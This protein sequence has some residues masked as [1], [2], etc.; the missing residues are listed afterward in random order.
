VKRL[1]VSCDCYI[2]T[3]G[4]TVKLPLSISHILS[5][6]VLFGFVICP[7][8]SWSAQTPHANF[9]YPSKLPYQ[10]SNF[11][12]WNE[13]DL[14][15]LL[16]KRIPGLGEELAT[17]H[18]AERGV[19][20][21]LTALLKE[22]GIDAEVQSDEPGP[23]A[24][25]KID[26]ALFGGHPPEE[27]HPAITFSLLTPRVL[28]GKLVFKD[29]PE[30]VE[31]VLESEVRGTEGRPF[32]ASGNT[33]WQKSLNQVVEREGYLESAVHLTHQTPR[34]DG[35]RYLVDVILSVETGPRYHISSITADGGP[36]LQGKDL[37]R[38]FALKPGDPATRP[39]FG[40][41]GPQIRA[42]YEHNGYADVDIES[43]PTL[44]HEHASVAYHLKVTPGPVY[45]LGSLTIQN[46]NAAQESK[47]RE[48]F[49]ART[50][51]L[52]DD[53]AI[54]R[55]YH[56]VADEPLLRG[57][58]FGFSPKRDKA[59]GNINLTLDFFKDGGE[60]TVTVK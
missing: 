25:A 27:P 35:D 52:Y 7:L 19:R 4:S 58:G 57:L 41:L 3:K 15:V 60:A 29:V 24:F 9:V 2:G 47:V 23:S 21:V 48:I 45:H 55:L 31:R 49:G 1:L 14:R 36:L 6:L 43:N 54:N 33:F 40:T 53:Q 44:D 59:A 51:D 32:N 26:P 20:D 50:G 22:K 39:P 46:L 13:E 11:V 16:K 37:S 28:I 42:L 10:F 8:N 17:T 38:F 12:W 5:G 56:K 18:D 34:K 30:D